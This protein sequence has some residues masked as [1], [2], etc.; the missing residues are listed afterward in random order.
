[1]HGAV[2][3]PFFMPIATRGV[4]KHCAPDELKTLGAQILL[5]NA[6]HLWRGPGARRLEQA[7]GLHRFMGWPGPILT[8]SGG[9]QVFSLAKFRQVNNAGVT[10]RDPRSGRQLTLTPSGVVRFQQRI[11]SDIILALDECVAYP[12]AHAAAALAVERTVAWARRSCRGFPFQLRRRPLLFGIV[13]G[14]TF[15][16]LRQQ[17]CEQTVA[18]NFDGYAIGGLA[19]GERRTTMLDVLKQTVAH[20]PGDKPRYLMGVGR[21]E[22]IVAAVRQGIDLF[23]CV[24]PTREARHGRLYVW[25]GAA[26]NIRLRPAVMAART[27]FYRTLNVT[28]AKFAAVHRPLDWACRHACCKTFTAAYLHHLFRIQEPLG[29]RIATLHNVGFYLDVMRSLRAGI[30][31]G[32]V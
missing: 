15:S 18:L 8:D 1:M 6:Y 27:S 24:I 19:V 22:E 12:A 17:S 32:A 10:F 4:V 21:P 29:A 11:G 30:A 3:G 2:D 26:R 7:G 5:S 28:N 31:R 16:G 13:Q 9:F 25:R 20:L 14:A 23:D